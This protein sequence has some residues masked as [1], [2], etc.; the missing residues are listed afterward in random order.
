MA[1]GENKPL[2]PSFLHSKWWRTK[3]KR[4]P[5]KLVRY[6][7]RD[8][9]VVIIVASVVAAVLIITGV[10]LSFYTRETQ[11]TSNTTGTSQ[12]GV[13]TSITKS[14]TSETG[15]S[16]TASSSPSIVSENYVTQSAPNSSQWLVLKSLNAPL[17][18]ISN[19]TGTI[20]RYQSLSSL[21]ETKIGTFC[22]SINQATGTCIS[23][24]MYEETGWFWDSANDLLY[25]H[26][27]GAPA[28]KLTV[29][30]MS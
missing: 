14:G 26:Y 6:W 24:K 10:V 3:I 25:V 1:K 11:S 19:L 21:N 27:V 22:D 15:T 12:S 16:S 2:R 9:R 13:S 28:V 29:T 4:L 18:V 17:Y 20:P 30:E 5:R 7:K 8:K 23:F